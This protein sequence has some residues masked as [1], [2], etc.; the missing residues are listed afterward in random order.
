M[1]PSTP[2]QA[3]AV[4]ADLG[5]F[6]LVAEFVRRFEQGPVVYVGPGDDAAVLRTP[7]GHAVVSTDLLVEGRHFRRDWGSGYDVG[8]RAAAQNIS[9]VNAM[10]GRATALTVGLALPPDLPAQWVLDL[11][12]GIA[13][14]AALVGASIIGG[15]IT[16]GSEVV[17]AVTVLGECSIAPVLRSGAR[18]GDVLAI[19]GRQGWAAAGLAVLGR[20][21]RSPRA[22]VEA[23][24][25]P[26][27][28]YAA[29]PAA[30]AGGATSMI[31]VSDGLV[32]D[33]GHLAVASGVLIDIWSTAF[34]IDEPL[35][36]VGAALGVDPLTFILG[37]GDDHPLV[38][39]FPPGSPL[40]EG[41]RPIGS[42]TGVDDEGP[43]VTVSG[44]PYEGPAGWSHF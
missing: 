2:P 40:P 9:D 39:T 13:A 32:A 10:G 34:E 14:E 18:S 22:V 17:V 3:G 20:G 30:A 28:P 26:E 31:D 1:T 29:G 19:A 8:R 36:A 6:G 24:Q 4:V 43:R 11:A 7:K 23:Y 15:D 42:V 16:S 38:A 25:R 41:F 21:F 44:D 12:D 27:P 33:V 5:E 37:G 35:Q